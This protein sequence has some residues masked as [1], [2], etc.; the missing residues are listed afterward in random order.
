M[1]VNELRNL[2]DAFENHNVRYEICKSKR[3]TPDGSDGKAIRGAGDDHVYR[4]GL[5]IAGDVISPRKNSFSRRFRATEGDLLTAAGGASVLASRASAS[6][7]TRVHP[8][9]RG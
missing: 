3:R 7:P 2:D 6:F 8:S 9:I 5:T 4:G 1:A